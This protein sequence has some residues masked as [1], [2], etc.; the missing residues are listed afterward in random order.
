MNYKTK[1]VCCIDNGI[2]CELA[3]KLAESFGHVYYYSP[4][5]EAFVKSNNMLPGYGIPGVER[6]NEPL[7][8]IDDI[9]LWVFPDLYHAGLQLH[10]QE[11]GK[12]VW[13]SRDGQELE[14]LRDESKKY[15]KKLGLPVGKYEVITGLENLRKYLK[16]HDNQFVKVS[17]TRGDFETFWSKNYKFIECKLDELE[18]NLGAK[19]SVAEFIVEEPIEGIEIG[20][21]GYSVDGKFPNSAIVGLEVKDKGYIGHVREYSG[22]PEEITGFIDKISDTLKSYQ[23]RNFM[24]TENRITKDHTSYMTDFCARQG[25]PPSELYINMFDNLAEIIW[26]GAE[27]ECV[28]P[29]CS[30]PWGAEVIIDSFWSDRNWQ[31]IQ[32]P[33]EIRDNVKLR[34]FTIIND[35][36]YV[37][38]QSEGSTAVGAV[39][40]TGDS[41][42]E[43][44]KNVK[45]ICEDVEGY[46]LDIHSDALDD[47]QKE[48][49]KLDE[50][51]I[52]L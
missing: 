4:W 31:P 38:P 52:T 32:F 29:V 13:G 27:G 42:D 5:E 49:D 50:M 43:A 9:D 14:L 11:L 10:L 17:V 39:V 28:D 48:L 46:Y 22:M 8:L 6:C 20:Y 25:S 26:K 34:Q 7:K 19:K 16:E 18:H 47:A 3:V 2:F 45:E 37:I 23:Y 24:S 1:S 41:M 44:I 15:L 51:G 35:Q 30:K 21:D 33:K 12:R 36:Y 40:A